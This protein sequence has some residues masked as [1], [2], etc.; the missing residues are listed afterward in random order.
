MGYERSAKTTRE[1]SGK[2]AAAKS[3]APPMFAQ[4]G[5]GQTARGTFSTERDRLLAKLAGPGGEARAPLT[6]RDRL[7]DRLRG[8]LQMKAMGAE[9]A[10]GPSGAE[11]THAAEAGTRGRGARLPHFDR[12][13]QAF[14]RFDVSAVQAHTDAEAE[15]ASQALGAQAFTFGDHVAFQGTPSLHTA[16]HEA[17][18][19]VQ[20]RA[21]VQLQGGVGRVGDPHEQH[22]DAVADAVVRGEAVDAMLARHA[23]S[24]E[25][26]TR[27]EAGAGVQ[28]KVQ[29]FKNGDGSEEQQVA[30]PPPAPQEAPHSPEAQESENDEQQELVLLEEIAPQLPQQQQQEQENGGGVVQQ[31]QAQPQQQV[32]GPQPGGNAGPFE[33]D[34][35]PIDQS[36]MNE[37]SDPEG[38]FERSV[39]PRPDQSKL[40]EDY[41]PEGMLERTV[42]PKS[43]EFWER[44]RKIANVSSTDKKLKTVGKGMKVPQTL[45]GAAGFGEDVS[46]VLES[47][48]SHSSGLEGAGHVLGSLGAINAVTKTVAGM[49]AIGALAT[50]R[51]KKK[52]KALTATKATSNFAGAVKGA[53]TSAKGIA[54]LAGKASTASRAAG[55]VPVAAVVQGGADMV[56][57]GVG[58]FLN[59]FRKKKM[60][61][62]QQDAAEK[63]DKKSSA[64]AKFASSALGAKKTHAALTFAKG[65]LA[66]AG[67][68]A[69]VAGAATPVGATLLVIASAAAIGATVYKFWKRYKRGKEIAN[70]QSDIHKMLKEAGITV[71]SDADVGMLDKHGWKS[72]KVL[73]WHS[74]KLQNFAREL[75]RLKLVLGQVATQLYDGC[76][77]V[78]PS[79][80]ADPTAKARY[81]RKKLILQTLGLKVGDGDGKPT[82]EQI[83]RA[84]K[85]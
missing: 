48:G 29:C 73:F 24:D 85:A 47:G 55:V 16:A 23:G 62:V 12:I 66:V 61:E 83:A 3:E 78:K 63:D 9:G 69:M 43:Q 84:L 11:A 39:E 5:F 13:Q 32:A 58:F 20:Q 60:K 67:G 37:D 27:G 42:E 45:E 65:A 22:A 31:Q 54:N 74:Q 46:R 81:E 70:P 10:S 21:G 18:H 77:C 57:G 15:E 75:T 38:L 7:T 41:D 1:A 6:E 44:Q 8:G 19:V 56:R 28:R 34:V 76:S 50:D 14:G 35:Q 59:R 82:K 71:P 4:A 17:A 40:S 53:A 52:D 30:V 68:V 51:T 25:R 79:T 49:R 33:R 36:H 26:A 72:G 64:S 2:T 80:L